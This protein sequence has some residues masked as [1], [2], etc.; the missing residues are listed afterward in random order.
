MKCTKFLEKRNQLYWNTNFCCVITIEL[1]ASWYNYALNGKNKLEGRKG[2]K[3]LRATQRATY[4]CRRVLQTFTQP[5]WVCCIR[6]QTSVLN[7][8]SSI[9][10]QQTALFVKNIQ[11]FI[12]S[13]HKASTLEF[14]EMKQINK[15]LMKMKKKPLCLIQL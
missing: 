9:N 1:S 11:L 7:R 8:Y 12:H 2:T 5:V 15:I 3:W 6:A 4:I 14:E 10:S 13:S